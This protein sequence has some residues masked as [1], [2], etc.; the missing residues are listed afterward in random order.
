M[1]YSGRITYSRKSLSRS[2]S[3]QPFSLSFLRGKTGI[4]P[5]K[6]IHY[7]SVVANSAGT[8]FNFTTYPFPIYR[9]ADLFLMYAEAMNEAYDTQEARN[10]AIRYID[11]VRARSGLKGVDYSWKTFSNDPTKH[12]RQSGL[13]SIIQQEITVEFIFE[14]HRFW[15][16]R[17]WK[18]ANDETSKLSCLKPITGWKMNDVSATS[19]E[20]YYQ[21]RLIHS[22]RFSPRDY[23]WPIHDGEILRNSNTL[24]NLGW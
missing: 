21:E 1:L 18:I 19:P 16:V 15:D 8:T 6:L 17:R 24:Q 7:N 20:D 22:Y 3:I 2:I 13:R 5:K 14:G 9:V 10:E 4:W 23:F 12:E 11:K